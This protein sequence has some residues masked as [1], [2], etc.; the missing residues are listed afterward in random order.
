MYNRFDQVGSLLLY[1]STVWY[2]Y[3]VGN[4]MF[5][6]IG[7][8]DHKSTYAIKRAQ[9]WNSIFSL[10]LIRLF[11][12]HHQLLAKKTCYFYFFICR[13]NNNNDHDYDNTTLTMITKIRVLIKSLQTTLVFALH[14]ELASGIERNGNTML[15]PI[16]CGFQKYCNLHSL[17]ILKHNFCRK[18]IK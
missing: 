18:A 1:I 13:S 8:T 6:I 10:F 11:G 14:S 3:C 15:T 2:W 16:I 12:H 9:P 4:S 7:F 5:F 17:F